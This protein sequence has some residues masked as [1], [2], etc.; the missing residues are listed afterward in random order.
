MFFRIKGQLRLLVAS[1][2]G[3][4]Y[5][6]PIDRSERSS[7]PVAPIKQFQL[8]DRD[9]RVHAGKDEKLAKGPKPK[10]NNGDAQEQELEAPGAGD[11]APAEPSYAD[12]VKNRDGGEMTGNKRA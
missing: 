11:E 2:D 3:F 1:Q 5:V 9:G 7:Q 10:V 4:L 8:T 12:R 6:F